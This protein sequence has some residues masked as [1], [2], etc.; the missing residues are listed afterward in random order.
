MTPDEM[1]DAAVLDGDCWLRVHSIRPNGYAGVHLAGVG[2]M[3]AHRVAYEH[4]VGPIPDGLDLDHLCRRRNCINPA[5]LDPVTRKVN[6]QR[7]T[8]RIVTCPRGHDYDAGNTYIDPKGHRRCRE[9][10]R[11]LDRARRSAVSQ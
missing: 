1:L 3:Y 10:K 11:Q 7:A 9:C 8:D 2:Q 5:H 6:I 4:M